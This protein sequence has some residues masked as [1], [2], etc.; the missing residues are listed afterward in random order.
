MAAGRHALLGAHVPRLLLRVCVGCTRHAPTRRLPFRSWCFC[1]CW[2]L[3]WCLCCLLLSEAA[4]SPLHPQRPRCA[5]GGSRQPTACFPPSIICGVAR[6]ET[7]RARPQKNER[8]R[9]RE[10]RGGYSRRACTGRQPGFPEGA[11]C[12]D[13][14]ASV[15]IQTT[16]SPLDDSWRPHHGHRRCRCC[17][18]NHLRPQARKAP[19]VLASRVTSHSETFRWAGRQQRVEY[20][21]HRQPQQQLRHQWLAILTAR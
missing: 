10:R 16:S 6:P 5:R 20:Y 21:G 8:E 11:A 12:V 19:P 3:C 1:F 14:V 13:F 17:R 15:R 7:T 9:E 2:C 4:C 18:R